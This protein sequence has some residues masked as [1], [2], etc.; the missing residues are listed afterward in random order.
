[1]P[2][3]LN[4]KDPPKNAVR[5]FRVSIF[6]PFARLVRIPPHF[7]G[8]GILFEP[9]LRRSRADQCLLMVADSSS[10]RNLRAF[11]WWCEFER[12]AMRNLKQPPR[13]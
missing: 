1:M 6:K 12:D 8:K 13:L 7:V 3:I 10:D 2:I 9:R 4:F 5:Y 11:T